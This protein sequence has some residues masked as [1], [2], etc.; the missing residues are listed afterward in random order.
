MTSLS[1]AFGDPT[2]DVEVGVRE[3]GADTKLTWTPQGD[4]LD[5]PQVA[6]RRASG[7]CRG[8]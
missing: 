5:V 8:P 2:R 7:D 4:P 3:A 6:P 1:I